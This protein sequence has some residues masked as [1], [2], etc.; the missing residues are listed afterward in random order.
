MTRTAAAAKLLT[1]GAR[2]LKTEQAGRT[3]GP[4]AS[5]RRFGRCDACRLVLSLALVG[6]ASVDA[7][8]PPVDPV[9]PVPRSA[10]DQRATT[11]AA[12]TIERRWLQSWFEGTPVVIRQG[13][14]AA[15]SLEIPREFCFDTG[16]SGVKPGLAVVL[17]KVAESLRRVPAAHLAVIATP[18][19]GEVANARLSAQRAA[20]VQQ[21]L[22]A[23]G[24]PAARLGAP[25]GALAPAVLLRIEASPM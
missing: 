2:R 16:R 20:Q 18:A 9:A 3:R 1:A 22:L 7:P 10:A 13:R 23:R 6:C 11:P 15:V 21:H 5:M 19:D 17:D 24:V 14:D 12:L 4:W 25:T 8:A